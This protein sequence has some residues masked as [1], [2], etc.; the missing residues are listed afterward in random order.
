MRPIRQAWTVKHR[1]SHSVGAL[2][3]CRRYEDRCSPPPAPLP[4]PPQP[5]LTY[6]SVSSMRCDTRE[7]ARCRPQLAWPAHL[8]ARP[9]L[10][11]VAGQRAFYE[12]RAH[13]PPP[14]S[15]SSTFFASSL[16][17]PPR[18]RCRPYAVACTTAAPGCNG[19]TVCSCFGYCC[20]NVNSWERSCFFQ[21][22][23]P[24]LPIAIVWLAGPCSVC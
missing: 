7:S 14:P 5:P 20:C 15:S 10:L 24:T 21:V 18:H 11:A 23:C 8:P 3:G 1:V 9:Q 17:Y 22:T 19:V 2:S 4:Q 16:L 6:P 13:P 12:Q